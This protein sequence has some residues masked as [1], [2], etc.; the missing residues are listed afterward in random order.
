MKKQTISNEEFS[1]YCYL[2]LFNKASEMIPHADENGYW[3]SIILILADIEKELKKKFI[4]KK[5]K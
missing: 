4:V 5:T 3:F 2:A 1:H